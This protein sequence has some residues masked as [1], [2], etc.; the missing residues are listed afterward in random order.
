MGLHNNPVVREPHTLPAFLSL[1]LTLLE[2]TISCGSTAEERLVTDYA[3]E[4]TE[5]RSWTDGVFNDMPSDDKDTKV[6]A[7][8]CCVKLGEILERFQGRLLGINSGF[9]Y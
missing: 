6:M 2:I 5:L 8:G 4:I 1:F 9:A 3:T 7:A